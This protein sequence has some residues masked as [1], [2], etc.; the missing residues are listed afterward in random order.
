MRRVQLNFVDSLNHIF[1]NNNEFLGIDDV[2]C[3]ILNSNVVIVLFPF[4]FCTKRNSYSVSINIR[5]IV[6][7]TIS[8]HYCNLLSEWFFAHSIQTE[9]SNVHHEEFVALW[10]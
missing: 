2:I 7:E 6:V 4:G 8:I 5:H 10:K 1:D 9:I 3:L